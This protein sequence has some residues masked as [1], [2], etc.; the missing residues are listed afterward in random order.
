M[1]RLFDAVSDLFFSLLKF[2]FMGFGILFLYGEIRLAA[3]KK[4]YKGAPKLSSF[5]LSV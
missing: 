3:I 4:I 5:D 2:T 1:N